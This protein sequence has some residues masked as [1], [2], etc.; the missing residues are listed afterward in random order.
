MCMITKKNCIYYSKLELFRKYYVHC[1]SEEDKVTM[2]MGLTTI[3]CISHLSYC[4]DNHLERHFSLPYTTVVLLA[5][6]GRVSVASS[7]SC[8]LL[9]DCRCGTH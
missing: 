2:R 1:K 8:Y 3:L 7:V 5:S 6:K 9:R 4:Y